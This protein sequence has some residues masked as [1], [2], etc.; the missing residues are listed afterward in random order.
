MTHKTAIRQG[1]EPI[2][3]EIH[4]LG[5]RIFYDTVAGKFYD[6]STDL[7]LETFNTVDWKGI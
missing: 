7:Y 1:L 5:T 2:Y 6:A 4:S 3:P